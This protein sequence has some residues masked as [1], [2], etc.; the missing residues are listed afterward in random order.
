MK[1][2]ITESYSL[3]FGDCVVEMQ[4]IESNIIDLT[5]TSPPYDNLRTYAGTLDWNF[6]IFKQVADELYRITKYGG[7]VVWVVGDIAQALINWYKELAPASETHIFFRD[8][9]FNDDVSKTNMV[10]ILEQNGIS[11]VRSL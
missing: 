2:V 4:K 10:A 7:V 3:L 5:V 8:S 6:D 9:A 11:H 1:D